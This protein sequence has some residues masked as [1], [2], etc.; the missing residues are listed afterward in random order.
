LF[1]VCILPNKDY[2]KY[3][4]TIIGDAIHKKQND[5]VYIV[6]NQLYNFLHYLQHLI[7][8]FVRCNFLSSFKLKY[9]NQTYDKIRILRQNE[10]IDKTFLWD[11][12]INTYIFDIIVVACYHSNRYQNNETFIQFNCYCN[13]TQNHVLYLKYKSKQDIVESFCNA[14]L[15]THNN[16]E[17]N[18]TFKEMI[19]LFKQYVSEL[20]FP[21]LMFHQELLSELKNKISYDDELQIFHNVTSNKLVYIKNVLNFIDSTFIDIENYTLNTDIQEKHYYEIS[22]LLDLFKL[23]NVNSNNIENITGNSGVSQ[24]HS[25]SSFITEKQFI[26]ILYHFYNITIEEQ[27]FLYNKICTL[28]NKVEDIKKYKQNLTIHDNIVPINNCMDYSIIN[29]KNTNVNTFE[30]ENNN[31]NYFTYCKYT[32]DN[33]YKAVS[34][35]YF[36]NIISLL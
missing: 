7:N 36:Y 29:D 22:E 16:L 27:R 19:Y 23:W 34:K 8:N 5:N 35:N 4:L 33:N 14:Y 10:N 21:K 24:S 31:T 18:I 20:N 25:M 3:L 17:M 26:N 13:E 30:E 6:D 2:A 12:Q 11:S 15:E 32:K 1:G 9:Y 28:W